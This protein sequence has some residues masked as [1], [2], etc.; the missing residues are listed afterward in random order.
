MRTEPNTEPKDEDSNEDDIITEDNGVPH[1][2]PKTVPTTSSQE[3]S[4][5]WDKLSSESGQNGFIPSNW[6]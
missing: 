2:I 4:S 6:V 5:G 1:K 3:L